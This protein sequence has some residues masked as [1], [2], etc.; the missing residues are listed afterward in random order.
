MFLAG[1]PKSVHYLIGAMQGWLLWP[2]MQERLWPLA[3]IAVDLAVDYWQEKHVAIGN[4]CL[5]EGHGGTT[6]LLR[7]YLAPAACVPSSVSTF[8]N[9]TPAI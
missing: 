9:K 3:P 7:I 1:I 4:A 5:S 2:M 6:E 8:V